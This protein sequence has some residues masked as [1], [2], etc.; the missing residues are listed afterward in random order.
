MRPTLYVAAAIALVPT[1]T[2]ELCALGDG[3]IANYD[4]VTELWKG[5]CGIEEKIGDGH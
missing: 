5:E 4:K 2:A 3:P 1:R